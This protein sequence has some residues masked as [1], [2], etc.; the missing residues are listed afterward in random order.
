MK[1]VV[2]KNYGPPTNLKLEEVEKP[3]PKEK[4]VLIKVQAVSLNASD[5]EM[6]KGEPY[7]TRMWG[8]FKPKYTTIGSDIAGVVEAVGSKV[9]QFK[10]GDEVLG[11]NF[12]KW[13]GMAEYVCASE[14]VLIAKPDSITF[15]QAAAIPQAAVVALQGLRDKGKIQAGEKV[16]IVGAGGGTGTFAIQLAKMIGANVTAVD[17]EIKLDLMRSLGADEVINYEKENCTKGD[18]K[19]DLILDLVGPHGVMEYKR[20]L[21]PKGRYAIVGG[22]IPRI[23]SVLFLG[24]IIS[25]LSSKKMGILAHAQ[26]QKDMSYIVELIQEGKVKPI[27]DKVFSLDES[28]EA[29]AYLTKG[30]AKGKVVI[31]CIV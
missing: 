29:M 20:I 14:S 24:G 15:E 19:Y 13:G 30:K 22:S 7:Y 1:A 28:A 17:S 27:I 16:L 18:Q 25:L 3:V 23:L 5:M 11:D 6:V 2:F 26:N 9:T 12:E 10:I 21:A 8:L 31:N 4:E